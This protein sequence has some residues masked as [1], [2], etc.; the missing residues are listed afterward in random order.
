MSRNE[1][2][3]LRLDNAKESLEAALL[4]INAKHFSSAI[5]RIYYAVFYAASALVYTKKLYPKTHAGMKTLFN[6]EFVFLV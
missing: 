5:N 2:I 4:L 1:Y 3:E 6:R